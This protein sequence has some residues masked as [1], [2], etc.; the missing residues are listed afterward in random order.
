MAP[1][2]VRLATKSAAASAEARRWQGS[3]ESERHRRFSAS[4]AG[5]T[6]EQDGFL[7]PT[8]EAGAA[9]EAK[10]NARRRN[11][12]G[13]P[14]KKLFRCP[15][16]GCVRVFNRAEHLRRHYRT[17]TGEKPFTCPHLECQKSFSRSDNLTQHLRIHQ[18]PDE[19]AASAIEEDE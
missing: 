16:E 5:G 6:P 14:T 7:E 2:A 4:S 13:P 8:M 18:T 19:K 17:H 3:V 10:A 11:S 12:V 1:G 15:M 9:V